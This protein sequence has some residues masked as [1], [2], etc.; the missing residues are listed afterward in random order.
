MAK[1]ITRDAIVDAALAV[2]DDVGMDG[3]TVRA[4]AARLDVK[5]PALYWHVRDKK[6]LL[7]EMGTRVWTE[8]GRAV[9]LMGDAPGNKDAA[10]AGAGD[11]RADGAGTAAAA[12][13]PSV[14]GW[15]DALEQYAHATRRGLLAHRDGAR[16][17]SGTALTDASLLRG[18]EAGLAWMEQQGFTVEASTDAV[19]ILTAFTVGSC[20]EEQERAQA[21]AGTYDIEKRDAAVDAAAHPRVAA[22]GRYG[23]ATAAGER[24]ATQLSVVLDSIA[25]LR[26]ASPLL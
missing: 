13:T 11:A 16:A 7:D 4:V 14:E 26:S 18:Q 22:S 15:R 3:L 19:S 20:I 5:A 24:F 23:Y 2:L 1:G 25:S 9:P 17:F 10:R 8:I 21:P 6:A 12:S